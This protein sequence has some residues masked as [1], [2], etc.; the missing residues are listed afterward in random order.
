MMRR[1]QHIKRYRRPRAVSAKRRKLGRARKLTREAVYRRAD[2]QCEICIPGVC[3]FSGGQ[4]HELRTRAR[5]G[6]IT[7]PDNTRLSCAQC[8]AWVHEHPIEAAARGL[9]ISASSNSSPD[10][11]EGGQS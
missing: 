3:E 11:T 7:D 5:G 10:A 8:H 9:L 1:R 6:S 2:G 4:V